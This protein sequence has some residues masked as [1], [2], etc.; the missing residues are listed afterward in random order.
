MLLAVMV[1]V[2]W[3]SGFLSLAFRSPSRKDLD[4]SISSFTEAMV[5][6]LGLVMSFVAG[7]YLTLQ[8][9]VLPSASSGKSSAFWI[10]SSS[11]VTLASAIFSSAPP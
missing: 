4:F 6:P 2:T 9:T 8:E 10:R 7:P 1:G 5:C 3:Q 11:K